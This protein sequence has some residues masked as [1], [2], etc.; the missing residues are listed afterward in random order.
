MMKKINEL[1]DIE[2]ISTFYRGMAMGYGKQKNVLFISEENGSIVDKIPFQRNLLEI[3]ED[4]LFLSNTDLYVYDE[5]LQDF[6]LYRKSLEGGRVNLFN[7]NFI[8]NKYTRSSESVQVTMYNG[9][10]DVK[11]WEK[12]YSDR[13]SWFCRG[14]HLYVTDL[15]HEYIDFIDARTGG[16]LNTLHFENPPISRF[17]YYYKDT[18]IVSL[19]IKPLEE[20]R[21]LGLDARTG[22]E[23]W[24]IEDAR[25]LYVQDLEKGYLY[26]I[27]G[28]LFQVIDVKNG[29]ILVYERL[30]SEIEKYKVFP[31]RKGCLS[32]NG[33]YFYSNSADCK[34]GLI[35]LHT[36]KIEF[37]VDLNF[38]NG[39]KITD[40]SY[41]NGRLYI[42]DTDKTLHI[43][44]E[45]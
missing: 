26:G 24:S 1:N 45:E 20:Y 36:H 30:S 13:I 4:K 35:N 9:K 2:S 17:I 40:L 5:E 43:F 10:S 32:P 38:S 29:K 16:V 15:M 25:Y 39:V 14:N 22:E 11:L 33:L 23:K 37:V 19:E 3:M 21:L 31:A 8:E 18:L 41:H 7:G 6:I 27:G 42:L 34:F 12:I 28:N 44:A